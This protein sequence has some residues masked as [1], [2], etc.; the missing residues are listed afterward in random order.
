MK[1]KNWINLIV[2]MG[3]LFTSFG[4]IPNKHSTAH[5]ATII[6]VK[7]G[8]STSTGCGSTWTNACEL[9]TALVD[10]SAGDEIWVAAGTYNPGTNR[11]DSFHLKSGVAIYGGF[12]GME[13]AREQRDWQS[14]P[15][16]L[17]GDIGVT[18]WNGDNS[19]HVV[20]GNGVD[21][22][23]ILDGFTITEGNADGP[24]SDYFR[25]GGMY[26]DDGSP[27]L[28]NVTF[29]LN[30]AT[31]GGGMY[32]DDGSPS[33]VNV[34]FSLNDA[35]EGGGIYNVVGSPY[36]ANVTFSSNSAQDFGGGMFNSGGS[37]SLVNVIFIGNSANDG[38]G[39]Y[40]GGSPSLTNVI[41]NGNQAIIYGGGMLNGG[42][43]SL[44]NVTF[45]SNNSGNGSGM[46]NGGAPTLTNT[47]FWESQIYN[48][49]TSLSSIQYSNVQGGCATI[50]GNNC[51]GGGNI[52]ADPLFARDPHP[53]PDGFWG[54]ADDDYGDLR[55]QYGSPVIDAGD[56]TAPG[57]AG[58]TTDLGGKP[59]FYD[60]PEIT[61]TGV[62]PAPVVDMGAYERQANHAPVAKDDSYSTKED[63]PLHIGGLGILANDNDPDGDS[64]SPMLV[65]EPI[66]GS[67][68]LNPDG[69]F[70]YLPAEDYFGVVTFTYRATDSLL[71]SNIATAT[72]NVI[73]VSEVYL[74]VIVR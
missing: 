54:T 74:P 61:D 35:R 11:E 38:G 62:G 48:D 49:E 34:T 53:G 19:Y 43:P 59:R 28:V 33:L 4:I 20:T 60:V 36:L 7:M 39:L 70:D 17:S 27:S 68:T 50:P 44:V 23:A 55:L 30:H 24:S 58:I 22:T 57:L 5:A 29:N 13:T 1:I 9:R 32:N 37:P 14:N 8:G 40:T 65:K 63:V 41:F 16:V 46:Y 67:L 21:A 18:V 56:N 72:I 52:D 31:E 12:A 71:D 15:T 45:S 66:S 73:E 6:H 25:G 69:S 64:L 51:S 10:A 47:I 42:S 26:N 3:L 2:V